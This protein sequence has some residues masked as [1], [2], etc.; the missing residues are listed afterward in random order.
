M[1]QPPPLDPPTVRLDVVSAATVRMPAAS[2]TADAPTERMKAVQTASNGSSGFGDGIALGLSQAIGSVSGLVAWVITARLL[3]R[4]QVGLASEFVSIFM[5]VGGIAQL[6]LGVG[7]L[8]W[9]PPAGRH[10][11]RLIWMAQAL[12]VPLAAGVGLVYVLV[13]PQIADT[14]AGTGP[15]LLGVGLFVLATGGWCVF[16]VHDFLLVALEK[17][18]WT[19]WRNASFAALRIGLLVVL[20]IAGFGAQGVVL[21]W[22]VPIVLWGVGSALLLVVVVRRFSRKAIGGTLPSRR[23]A[24]GFLGPTALGQVA[25]A[26]QYNFVPA[27][28]TANFGPDIGAQ[29]FLVWQAVAVVEV[30]AV[31]FM[32]SLAVNVAREPF[33]VAEL[34]AAARRRLLMIFL[35]ALALGALVAGPALNIIFGPKYAEA[36]NILRLVLLGL[37]FRLVVV[38]ELGVRQAIGK[39]LQYT[40]LQLISSLLVLGVAVAIRPSGLESVTALVPVAIGYVVVQVAC[41]AAVLF[42]PASRRTDAEVPSP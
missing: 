9:V 15:H 28:I 42:F 33:R 41:A 8:R 24:A 34:A 19:V 35:P 16:V 31:F 2:A 39:A 27:L 25:A 11:A 3:D 1:T 6:N 21:S 5:L 13:Y 10:A 38:H 14:A 40:R 37:A 22:V 17:P 29:F 26:L 32:N 4:E 20:C 12:I 36:D 30:T 18:W 7:L 23:E